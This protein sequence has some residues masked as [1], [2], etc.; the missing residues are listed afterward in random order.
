MTI[1]SYLALVI[2]IHERCGA[3]T[4]AADGVATENCQNGTTRAS[5]A[6]KS[7]LWGLA[8][9]TEDVDQMKTSQTGK[10]SI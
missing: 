6:S 4:V 10:V 8:T 9:F 2:V 3:C 1:Y 5:I 7:S